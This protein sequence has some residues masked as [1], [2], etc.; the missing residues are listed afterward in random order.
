[1]QVRPSSPFGEKGYEK[2]FEKGGYDKGY[3]KGYDKGYDKGYGKGGYNGWEAQRNVEV[4]T[5]ELRKAS[6][7]SHPASL[8]RVARAAIIRTG[9][10]GDR[11]W[12]RFVRISE[13][14]WTKSYDSMSSPCIFYAHFSVFKK[15]HVTSPSHVTYLTHHFFRYY[16]TRYICKV[17]I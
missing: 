2:G 4:E 5:L 1:M 13:T 14:T 16:F 7:A 9:E 12:L 6:K 10:V 3:Y 8:P 15:K 11:K 17:A